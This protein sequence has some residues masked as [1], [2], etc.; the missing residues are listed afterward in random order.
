M[1]FLIRTKRLT[2]KVQG[3]HIKVKRFSNRGEMT[4]AIV[5]ELTDGR[6]HLQTLSI[7]ATINKIL[8]T[9]SLSKQ[10]KLNLS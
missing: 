5:K 6:K 4:W 2:T 7:R 1:I 8:E 10:Q 3:L 9:G